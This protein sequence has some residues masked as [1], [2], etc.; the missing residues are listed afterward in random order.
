[1]IMN[2]KKVGHEEGSW[3]MF[4]M[5]MKMKTFLIMH[6]LIANNVINSTI[7]KR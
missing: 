1:M 5:H 3:E 4:E 7:F 6:H 2:N